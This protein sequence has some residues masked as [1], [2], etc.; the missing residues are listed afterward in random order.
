MGSRVQLLNAMRPGVF[1]ISKEHP[2]ASTYLAVA[3][4]E[5]EASSAALNLDKGVASTGEVPI[6]LARENPHHSFINYVHENAWVSF[7]SYAWVL[8]SRSLK[9]GRGLLYTGMEMPWHGLACSVP[10]LPL[11]IYGVKAS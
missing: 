11:G 3:M 1:I 7:T 4:G 8:W 9:E 10:P 6:S 5:L 2:L